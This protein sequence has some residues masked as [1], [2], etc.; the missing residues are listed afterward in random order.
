VA[1]DVSPGI[2]SIQAGDVTYLGDAVEA[3]RRHSRI[4]LFAV[5]SQRV[6]KKLNERYSKLKT[7]AIRSLPGSEVADA[8]RDLALF[9]AKYLPKPRRK[10]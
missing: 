4:G 7:L 1:K 9:P 3:G 6:E 8:I 2:H 10:L 5:E